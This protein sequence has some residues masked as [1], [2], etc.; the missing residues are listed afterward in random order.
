MRIQLAK[1]LAHPGEKDAALAEA[2]R[3]IEL[4]PESKDAFGGPAI[5]TA[6][7][8]VY[9]VLGENDR[10]IAILD[11][12]LSRPSAATVAVLKANPGW[13]PLRSDPRF[14]GLI[15]KYA[16]KSQSVAHRPL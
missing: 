9:A 13:D 1:L 11:G 2:Q 14:Q 12:L 4:L 5:L 6:A 3:A 16:A 10:A 8:E 15:Y 7:A